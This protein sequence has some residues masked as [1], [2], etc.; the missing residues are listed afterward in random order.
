VL[1]HVIPKPARIAGY[2]LHQLAEAATGGGRPLFVDRGDHLVIRTDKPLTAHP[3]PTR[4][5]KE[6]DV[7]AFELRACVARKIKGRKIYFPLGDWRSRHAWLER[8]AQTCGFEVLA[9]R[10]TASI[11][12]IA[13]PDRTFS[14]DRTDFVGV[15]RVRDL[16]AFE[17]ALR[18]G[19]GSTARAFGF[20]M[21][22]IN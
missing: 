1:D 7:L 10:S 13:K 14:I 3:V 17:V 4:T 12:K 20:G 2:T 16:A 15:L 8:K 5:V 21:L 6:G 18:T 22:H 19:I 11:A 9:L